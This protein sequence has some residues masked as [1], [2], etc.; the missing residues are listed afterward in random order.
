MPPRKHTPPS[1]SRGWGRGKGSALHL[2][3]EVEPLSLLCSFFPVWWQVVKYHAG[4][5]AWFCCALNSF[6]H[7]L[8]YGECTGAVGACRPSTHTPGP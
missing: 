1:P 7:V 2:P 5:E 8:M 3:L 4:G 6:I